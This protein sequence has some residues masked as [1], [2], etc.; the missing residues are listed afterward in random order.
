MSAKVEQSIL[1]RFMLLLLLQRNF[2]LLQADMVFVNF[3][4]K[5]SELMAAVAMTLKFSVTAAVSGTFSTVSLN[6]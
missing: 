3:C 1:G 6:V 2:D 5:L 4:N